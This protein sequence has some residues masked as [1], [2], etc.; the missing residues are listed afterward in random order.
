MCLTTTSCT[1]KVTSA[2]RV[3]SPAMALRRNTCA[4]HQIVVLQY[5]LLEVGVVAVEQD[6]FFI[7]EMGFRAGN[8]II[9]RIIQINHPL[10]TRNNGVDQFV[11]A[12]KNLAMLLVDQRLAAQV[13]V[14]PHQAH[15]R[16][17][18]L[19]AATASR[20]RAGLLDAV[21]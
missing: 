16:E 9:E 6:P 20:G 2:P 10:I 7:R 15:D 18:C 11:R 8:Q 21:E 12:V 17:A 19:F 4:R 3:N 1:M 5:M 14:V 13:G